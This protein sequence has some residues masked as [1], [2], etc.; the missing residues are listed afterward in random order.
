MATTALQ[1]YSHY[2]LQHTAP[3]LGH[4]NGNFG[5]I[6]AVEQK[7]KARVAVQPDDAKQPRLW[8]CPESISVVRSRHS[9]YSSSDT[10]SETESEASASDDK[11]VPQAEV[12]ELDAEMADAFNVNL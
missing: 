4:L 6:V 1:H 8:L 11:H 7:D 5:V 12:S 2:S 10:D 3:P 9:G